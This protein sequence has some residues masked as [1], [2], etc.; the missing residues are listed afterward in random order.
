[1][2]GCK[3]CGAIAVVEDICRNCESEVWTNKLDED[4]LEYLKEAQLDYFSTWQKEDEIDLEIHHF[5][6][7]LNWKLLVAKEEILRY[8]KEYNWD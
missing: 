5:N 8:S 1:M 6:K 2:K 4:E 3:I 7:D